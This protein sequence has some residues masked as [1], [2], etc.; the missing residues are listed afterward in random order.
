MAIFQSGSLGTLYQ[1]SP[2]SGYQP[3]G[4]TENPR[5]YE[6]PG[7]RLPQINNAGQISATMEVVH[8]GN[9]V[10][11]HAMRYTPGVGFQDLGL[12][13]GS[14]T[15]ANGINKQGWIVGGSKSGGGV[16][17]A[18]VWQGDALIPLG[19]REAFAINDAGTVLGV[20]DSLQPVVLRDG[21]FIP[22]N[23]SGTSA[24]AFGLNSSGQVVGF[25]EQPTLSAF[26]WTEA[27][28]TLDLN[29]LVAPGNGWTLGLAYGINESGQIL[30]LGLYGGNP[31]VFRLDPVP[32]PGTWA[33][34][35]LGSICGWFVL[36]KRK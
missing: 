12:L 5:D 24:K 3:I 15:W 32:E 30:G 10:L 9:Q 6:L 36:R 2:V 8:S 16:E 22:I 4:L 21:N 7:R 25:V 13:N 28:G 35:G 33:L 27:E 23:F 19:M 14:A 17:Q 20:T 31:R 26:I 18:F 11:E 34:F 29:T 1:Y